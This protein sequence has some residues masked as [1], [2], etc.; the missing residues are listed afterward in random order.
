MLAGFWVFEYVFSPPSQGSP[1]EEKESQRDLSPFSGCFKR[2]STHLDGSLFHCGA[3]RPV[4]DTLT[5]RKGFSLTLKEPESRNTGV[6]RTSVLQPLCRVDRVHRPYVDL[7]RDLPL[8]G[9]LHLRGVLPG[10]EG[11]RRRKAEMPVP[12]DA[13]GR[14]R[15]VRPRSSLGR[16]M[17]RLAPVSDRAQ[18]DKTVRPWQTLSLISGLAAK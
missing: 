3:F 2:R 5:P 6:H 15:S 11:G 8:Q 16:S 14:D 12:V 10:G 13:P 4:S 9:C 18:L 1:T 17:G 7:R